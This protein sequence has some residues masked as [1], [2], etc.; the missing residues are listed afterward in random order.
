MITIQSPN[1]I[2]LAKNKKKIKVWLDM[3]GVIAN[4]LK[5]ALDLCD[6]NLNDKAIR[7]KIKTEANILEDSDIVDKD[8]L[9]ANIRKEGI[10]FWQNLEL[11]PWSK[12]LYQALEDVADEFSILSSPGSFPDVASQACAGKTLWLEK[13]FN[14]K[15]DYFFGYNK[16]RCAD[17]QSILIDD[18]QHKIDQFIEAGG[19]GFLWPNSL[20][21]IDEDVDIDN[22]INELIQ[23]IKLEIGG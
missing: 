8:T 2:I 6:V 18:G 17:E 21:L 11:F 5:G 14:N 12:K 22:I 20:S 13:H 9:W 16:H 19:H 1:K 3:D 15:R 7:K 4:W 23:Y 10:D